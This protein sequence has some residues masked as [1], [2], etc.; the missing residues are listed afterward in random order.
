MIEAFM[1]RDPAFDGVFFTGVTTTG[2][3]CRTTCPARKPLPENVRFF[4]RLQDAITAGFRPCRR[5]H[6][7]LP[8]GT[9]PE[10]A[11]DLV[12][13][14]ES[15]PE[16]RWTDADL[17]ARGIAPE[18]I[19]RWF[20]QH[21]G[22]TFHEYARARR[23]AHALSALQGGAQVTRAAYDS[24]YESLSG[25]NAAFKEVVGRPPSS[26]RTITLVSVQRIATP[27]GTMVA[28][29]TEAGL[30]LLEFADRRTLETQFKRLQKRLPDAVLLSGP[31]PHLTQ[32]AVELDE[33]F[34]RARTQFTV[35]LLS[36]GTPFQESVWEELKRIRAG[37][38]RSYG[39]VADAIGRPSAVRAVAKANGDNCMAILIP[40]HRVIGADGSLTGYGG[41]LW[42]KR[43][44]LELEIQPSLL[45]PEPYEET[46]GI[47][48]ASGSG[49]GVNRRRSEQAGRGNAH[50][51]H[52]VRHLLHETPPIGRTVVVATVPGDD[53]G[54]VRGLRH[55]D[56]LFVGYDLV[57]DPMEY[58]D[59]PVKIPSAGDVVETIPHQETGKQVLPGEVCGPRVGGDQNHGRQ[60]SFATQIGNGSRAE[61]TAHSD[62][63]VGIHIRP[64]GQPVVGSHHRLSD[65][66][67]GRRPV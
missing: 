35:P 60:R 64:R 7:L 56:P 31:N 11:R 49:V 45:P 55:P 50:S 30:L 4:A 5:C 2:I 43:R 28:A 41:G 16:R 9:P 34:A 61:G 44:L 40:C 53:R 18:R 21:H 47:L 6:P 8:R 65:R 24:G 12:Q 15:D 23:M 46:S 58:Q 54:P 66:S 39:Q 52:E 29:A 26:A 36:T 38:T 42:R 10:W 48:R 13:E 27:L 63:S 59:G 17:V 19:R 14:L 51:D 33:Y 57:P 62:N 32:L 3:F 67:S 25:F 1:A 22:I 37:E 20:K